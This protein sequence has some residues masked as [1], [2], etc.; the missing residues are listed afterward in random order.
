MNLD[1]YNAYNRE[2]I[3]S[4]GM[5]SWTQVEGWLQ[6]AYVAHQNN[7][8]LPPHHR[9]KILQRC[10]MLMQKEAE[11]LARLIATEGGKPLVDARIEVSRAIAGVESCAALIDDLRGEQVPMDIAA[12]SAG[13]MAFSIVE[14]IGV[15]VSVS[16]FNHPLNL[17]VHQIA[18]AIAAGC[19]VLIKPANDTPLCAQRMVEI[20][21]QAGLPSEYCRLVLCDNLV[22]EQLVTDWRVGFFSF[23]GSASVGW[24]LKSK[25]APG[26]R[27]A[28]EHGGAAPVLVHKSADLG[29]MIGELTRGGFY[30]A[31]QV[32]VSVQRVYVPNCNLEAFTEAYA[33]QV[34]QLQVGDPLRE[35]T[36]VGPL[37]RPAEVARVADWV[38]QARVG[39]ARLVCGGQAVGETCYQP[40]ILVNPPADAIV[41]QKEIFGP[42]VCVYGYDQWDH[43]IALANSLPFAFQAAVYSQQLEPAL[44]AFRRL[45][46]S[47]VMVNDHTAFR[48]DHMP[49]AGRKQSGYGVGGMGYSLQDLCHHKMAVLRY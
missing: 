38:S 3:A 49:F 17:I 22:A 12:D 20:V 34:E 11:N 13:R 7:Q 1:V 27:C 18:P 14:P 15:V 35:N 42:V 16:A 30:H 44:D 33:Q 2:P 5:H 47:A 4:L 19:P 9:R 25:L 21:A 24:Y 26:T 23:I 39:G 31:G 41:S 46:A 45:N 37:I 48:V 8:Q 40:T 36:Q 10:A 32:C 28:L 29:S 43:A 6:E